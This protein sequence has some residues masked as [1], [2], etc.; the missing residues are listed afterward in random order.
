MVADRFKRG[1]IN[2]GADSGILKQ[3]ILLDRLIV[4]EMELNEPNSDHKDQH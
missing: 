3:S 1:H 4:N 2:M